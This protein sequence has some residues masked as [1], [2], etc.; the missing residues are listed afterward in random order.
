VIKVGAATEYGIEG[1][2]SA[3]R[4]R[5]ARHAPA[6]KRIVPAVGHFIP[7]QKALETFKLED[8]DETEWREYRQRR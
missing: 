8:P 2:E 6:V 1:E 3:S 7:R 5:D 4:R